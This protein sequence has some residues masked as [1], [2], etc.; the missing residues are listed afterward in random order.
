MKGSRSRSN[1]CVLL[2]LATISLCA[3]PLPTKVKPAF[4]RVVIL[5]VDG[6]NADLLQ[7]QMRQLNPATGRSTLPW[8]SQIFDQGGTVFENFYVRGISLSAPS[9]SILDTGR[10]AVIRGNAEYDRYTGQVYDYLNFFPFYIG[11]A[12]KHE[13]DMPGVEVLDRAGIPLLI[14][15]FQYGDVLQ[16]FQLF[17][18]GVRWETLKDALIRS[19]SGAKLSKLIEN[20]G[21]SLEP[22]LAKETETLLE[23]GVE[24]SSMLYLDLFTG[25]VDHEGHATSDAATLLHVLKELDTLTGRIWTAIQRGPLAQQT[26]L[27]VVSDHGMNNVPG[28]VSQTFS[29]PDLLNSPEGG[30]H[31]VVTDREQL[32]DFKLKGI[33]PLVHRVVTPST[34][35]FYLKGQAWQYPTAWLDIDG[36][37]RTA[38]HLRNSDL[39]KIHILLLQLSRND[40]AL[41]LRKAIAQDL[42]ETIEK[43]RAEWSGTVREMD[44]ELGAL[45]EA[46]TARKQ[47]LKH[48]PKQDRLT[49]GDLRVRR[50]KQELQAWESEHQDYAAYVSHLKSLLGFVPDD[51]RE[52]TGKIRDL[53]PEMTLGDNN[54]V[55]DLEQYIVGPSPAGMITD[56]EG[57]LDDARSFLFVNYFRLLTAQIVKNNPQAQLSSRPIDFT[58]MRLPDEKYEAGMPEQQHAYWLYG[59]D[60]RQIVILQD[61]AG[62]LKLLP[63]SNLTQNESGRTKW[64]GQPWR[65]GLP[66][67]LFEDAD[68]KLPLGEDRASWLSAW[69]TEQEWFSAVHLCRY[70]NGVIGITEELSPL[71]GLVPGPPG[72][73][74]ILRRYEQRRRELVRADFHVFASDHWNFNVRF[75]NPGGNH[76]SFLRISTHS[77]WMMAGAGI[78]TQQVEHPYDSLNFASTLLN[79]LG[80][81]PPMPERVVNLY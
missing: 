43:H 59:D 41:T 9:W 21:P 52:F 68:L 81:T 47:L 44:G 24:G 7:S 62:R 15:R 76:G 60:D 33:N 19:V 57:R 50:L 38:V 1:V 27:V 70:S 5:K 13:V 45:E 48:M 16:S 34:G 40:L 32:S 35:S 66:L 54:S 65:P 63:V 39:N 73:N 6:L 79:L 74:P 55:R 3:E 31:H 69:H 56:A 53:I 2:C 61:S 78:P 17:Q 26:L 20:S 77:V 25:D 14:D 80:K 37:E 22:A 51:T 49:G 30:G 18:R 67:S 23:N 28:I 8:F 29:L 71:K 58:A 64:T 12:R 36:N 75:P 72:I 11:N 46:V 10:H 42:R 4:R